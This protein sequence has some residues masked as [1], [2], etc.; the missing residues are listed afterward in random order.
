MAELSP[1]EFT[2]VLVENALEASRRLLKADTPTHRREL[3]RTMFS[4]I[5]GLV[6]Q[7]KQDILKN[8]AATGLSRY[9]HAAM[10]EK[11]CAVDEHG[12]VH[13]V[14]RSVPLANGIRLVVRIIQRYR[15]EF[16]AEFAD[17]GWSSLKAAINV[18]HRLVHPKTAEDLNVS[19]GEIYKVMTA[20][21]WTVNLVH[22]ALKE[23]QAVLDEELKKLEQ[24]YDYLRL[25][26]DPF[27]GGGS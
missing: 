16:K 11:A 25:H 21:H 1:R 20:F 12:V 27:G 7:L 23:R 19:R 15:P 14:S 3:V 2:K 22:D 13:V 10:L 9:E 26:S 8:F 5:E 17:D 6:W 18:R 4:G 24:E